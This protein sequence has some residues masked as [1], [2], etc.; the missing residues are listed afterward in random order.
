MRRGLS[1]WAVCDRPGQVPGGRARGISLVEVMVAV[2]ILTVSVYL[3]SSTITA[4]I[5]HSSIKRE[6]AIA[7]E[8]SMNI[9]ERMRSERFD[10]LFASYND[11]PDDDPGGAGTAPGR[12]FAVHGL[13]AW[14][15]DADALVGEVLLPSSLAVLREDTEN[16]LLSMP[17]DLNADLMIDDQDHARDYVLL[18][19]TVRV[20]WQGKGG[21]R[22]FQMSTMFAKLEKLD[23]Q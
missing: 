21:R 15:D 16:R 9:L 4:A 11:V 23:E 18:P 8:A 2:L 12:N 22:S 7:V 13:S 20:A 6:R 10:E 17:R 19:V 14:D 5:A 1:R 3:L